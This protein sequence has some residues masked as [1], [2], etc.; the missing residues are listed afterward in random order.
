MAQAGEV[1]AA[2]A[3]GKKLPPAQMPSE[4]L[5]PVFESSPHSLCNSGAASGLPACP[6]TP[7][8]G[9]LLRQGFRIGKVNLAVGYE[10]GSDLTEVPEICSL[11]RSLE[12]FTGITNL[13][14]KLVPVFDLASYAGVERKAGAKP[15]L[16][17]LGH[18]CDAA[19]MLIDGMPE[20][21]RL[22]AA[23]RGEATGVPPALEGCIDGA[24]LVDGQQWW[25]LQA[26]ALLSDLEERLRELAAPK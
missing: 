10:D 5:S 18:A 22:N 12:W 17:V 4:A 1:T 6:Q 14:G 26:A 9:V 7:A 8:S 11:P 19:G 20:R 25:S 21:L 24:F 2:P 16:L 15:M 3:H 23:G 13:H